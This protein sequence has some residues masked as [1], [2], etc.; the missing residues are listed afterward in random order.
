M[1]TQIFILI[2]AVLGFIVSIVTIYANRKKLFADTEK[3]K[4]E[5]Q[6]TSVAASNTALEAVISALSPLREEVQELREEVVSLRRA[7]TNLTFEVSE[8]QKENRKLL[9]ENKKL[10]AS[11]AKLRIL[12]QQAANG[13]RLFNL[14]HHTSDAVLI[15]DP[16][17]KVSLVNQNFCDMFD[18]PVEPEDMV[19]LDCVQSAYKLTVIDDI[20]LF[21]ARVDELIAEWKVCSDEP[22]TLSDGTLVYR[23]FIPLDHLDGTREIAWIY[24]LNCI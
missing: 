4:A 1:D 5:T 14:I 12:I 21:L 13:T 11:I 20:D 2:G 22:L 24:K 18:I 10:G 23:S 15:E 8:L 16:N 6:V 3:V 7:N 19:G 17:R 9:Q